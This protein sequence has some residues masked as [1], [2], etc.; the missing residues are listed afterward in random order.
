[1][2]FFSD[3]AASSRAGGPGLAIERFSGRL[4]STMPQLH[5]CFSAIVVN[6]LGQSRKS[7]NRVISENIGI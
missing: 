7:R 4:P 6:S 3:K 5:G 2:G 1:M